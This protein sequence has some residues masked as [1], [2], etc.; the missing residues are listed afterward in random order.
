M[1]KKTRA[2]V[3]RKGNKIEKG[4][5]YIY[6]IH[7]ELRIGVAVP[8]REREQGRLRGSTEGA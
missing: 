4:N 8:G 5:I 7:P 2:S 3:E 1:L 6:Y